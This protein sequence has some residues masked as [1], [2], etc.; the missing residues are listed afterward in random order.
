M[1]SRERAKRGPRGRKQTESADAVKRVPCP[2]LKGFV[3][4]NP[5]RLCHPESGDSRMRDL[6]AEKGNWRRRRGCHCC[7]RWNFCRMLYVLPNVYLKA[8]SQKP[9]SSLQLTIDNVSKRYGAGNWA[10]HNFSL[11]L[12]PGVLGLLGPNGAGKCWPC[13]FSGS[14]SPSD[15]LPCS[16]TFEAIYT[17]WWYIGPGHQIPGLD[18]MGTTPASSSPFAYALA[19]GFLAT[20]AYLRRRQSLGYA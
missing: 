16:S 13:A 15:S 5:G 2:A 20:V 19:T 1:S 10:L 3:I 9:G 11:Q 17:I 7:R 12:G 8:S 14:R 4:L 18:F 6:T